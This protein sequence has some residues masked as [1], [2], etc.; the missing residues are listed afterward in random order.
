MRDFCLP[1]T[2]S[3]ALLARRASFEVAL[4]LKVALEQKKMPFS[5]KP[6]ARARERRL[7]SLALLACEKGAYVSVLEANKLKGRNFRTRERGE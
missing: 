2:S 5:Y 7:L 6:E 4:F 3:A 1:L